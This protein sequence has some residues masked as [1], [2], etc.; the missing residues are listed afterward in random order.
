M[1][2]LMDNVNSRTQLVGRNRMELL[3]FQLGKRQ[4]FG[5]NVFKVREVIKC[6]PLTQ[7]PHSHPVIRGMTNMRGQTITV[8]DLAMAIGKPAI[9][10]MEESFVI[11][12]EYNRHIQGFMVSGVDRIINMNWAD[13]KP[14]PSGLGKTTF[15]TA[16]TNVDDELVEIID[17]EKVM[18]DVLGYTDEVDD[19][20]TNKTDK[21]ELE[22]KHVLVID[23]SAMA[24]KQIV[25]VLDQLG[26]SHT[27]AKN[28]REGY[29]VLLEWVKDESIPIE[30]RC[31]LVLSDVEMPEMDGYTL[32]KSIKSH[33]QMESLS[34]LLHSSLSGSFNENMVKKSRCR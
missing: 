15:L 1:T 2:Q 29:D 10:D 7:A 24:R 20:F 6:P 17:V 12:S 25:K 30:N 16:V 18:A 28:G 26:V 27:Q 9:E 19:E 5:I 14:P 22:N 33:P 13:I 31:S 4:R 11:V 32:T 21:S 3:L 34:V 23:D 8:M